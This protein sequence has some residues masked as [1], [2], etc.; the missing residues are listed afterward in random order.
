M[1]RGA[2]ALSVDRS[3][4]M[5]EEMYLLIAPGESYGLTTSRVKGRTFEQLCN[6]CLNIASVELSI[7]AELEF[8]LQHEKGCPVFDAIDSMSSGRPADEVKKLL[9]EAI[10]HVAKVANAENN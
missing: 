4:A 6:G 3:E 1:T 8:T 7:G 5:S 2:V 9:A 10:A